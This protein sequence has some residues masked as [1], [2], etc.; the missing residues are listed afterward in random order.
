MAEVSEILKRE[1]EGIAPELKVKLEV[2]VKVGD[3]LGQV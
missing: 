3:N 2:E 1:M